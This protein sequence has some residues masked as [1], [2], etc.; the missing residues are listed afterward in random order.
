[1]NLGN[2]PSP[3]ARSAKFAARRRA[4]N[5]RG[6]GLVGFLKLSQELSDVLLSRHQ[7]AGVIDPPPAVINTLVVSGLKRI[8]AQIKQLRET[9]WYQWVLPHVQAVRAL[10]GENNLPL[11]IAHA[12]Q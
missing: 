6:S 4:K 7:D 9:Q 1:M 3:S 2:H 12:D 5:C 10:F 11:V 8:G